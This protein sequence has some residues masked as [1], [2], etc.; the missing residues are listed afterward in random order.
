MSFTTHI[1]IEHHCPAAK[2]REFNVWLHNVITD[3]LRENGGGSVQFNTNEPVFSVGGSKPSE[4]Y[5]GCEKS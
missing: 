3:K 1:H 5:S 2:A 4:D